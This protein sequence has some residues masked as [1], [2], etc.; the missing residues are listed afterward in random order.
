MRS[1]CE[2]D[3][4]CVQ[5][6]LLTRRSGHLTVRLNGAVVAAVGR[7]GALMAKHGC[8]AELAWICFSQA[9]V[10]LASGGV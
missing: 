2:S 1:D 8:G 9:V 10:F 5:S 3:S 7:A 6:T 4:S